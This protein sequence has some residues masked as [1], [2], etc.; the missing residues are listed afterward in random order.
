MA[1]DEEQ[2]WFTPD[3]HAWFTAQVCLASL[4]SSVRYMNNPPNG[5]ISHRE[6]VLLQQQLFPVDAEGFRMPGSDWVRSRV[7]V[8]VRHEDYYYSPIGEVDPAAEVY[9][10]GHPLEPRSETPE[11][12]PPRRGWRG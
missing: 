4:G 6:P 3:G 1:S 10:R 2:P 5:R 9:E 11:S 7:V 8:G 12:N